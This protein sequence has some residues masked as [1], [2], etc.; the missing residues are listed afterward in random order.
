M[1]HN[2]NSKSRAVFG[3]RLGLIATTVGSAVGLGNIWRFPFEA[4][5]HGG[6]AFILCYVIF[7]FL[8]GVPV[9]C[10]EFVL[11][12]NSRSN[13]FGAVKHYS[14][15]GY[16]K[17]GAIAGIIASLMIL[18]FYSVVAGWTLEYLF[19]SLT[20]GLS[21]QSAEQFHERFT[22]FSTDALRPVLWTA[23]FLLANFG[24][25]I[26]GVT[27]GIEKI[28]N[29]MMPMLFVILIA[30]CINS[31]SLPGARHA[32]DFLFQPDFS[33]LTP[34][35][36]LGALGQ[37]FFSLSLG[38]GCLLTYAS[39]FRK[40]VSLARNAVTVASLDTIV[41]ILAGIMIFPAVFTFGMS[42]AA[43][44][45]LVFEVLPSIFTRMEGGALWAPLFFA[46]LVL[47]S[48]TST[49]SMSEI[50][51]TY[52]MEERGMTR[53]RATI[54]NTLIA[55]VFGTLCAL[56]FG[57]LSNLKIFGLT[58]FELFDYTSSNILLPLGGMLIAIFTGWYVDR[59][60]VRTELLG[61]RAD[62]PVW[63]RVLIFLIRFIA[64]A[65]IL[66]VFLSALGLI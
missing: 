17:A 50:S 42:P 31:L 27:K 47:A 45:A 35:V 49:I 40:D 64:P 1:N 8:L 15:N 24:I 65:G 59:R 48:L 46:L 23:L 62:T 60:T 54:L 28:S 21:L 22:A 55:L 36:V 52:F 19:Q 9:I 58:I 4:G 6:G 2:K 61:E 63:Y 11:G 33:A 13:Y 57:P 14:S 7:I 56:S 5:V 18:S 16:W 12:R 37:A 25:L 39:Y 66:L 3:T 26:R 51:I 29:I 32:M 43:G 34:S 44:P 20:G 41:A 30:F 10:C 38:L 53:R